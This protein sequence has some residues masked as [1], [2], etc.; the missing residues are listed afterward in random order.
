VLGS[1][2]PCPPATDGL[3]VRST[4]EHKQQN[5]NK[6]SNLALLCGAVCSVCTNQD[7]QRSH[8]NADISINNMSNLLTIG[9]I[10]FLI[11]LKMPDEFVILVNWK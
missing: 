8:R 1:I 10:L 3:F 9:E 7:R 5:K 11:F 6:A 2:C 4:I